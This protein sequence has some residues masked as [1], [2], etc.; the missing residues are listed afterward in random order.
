[1][2]LEAACTTK[3]A[4]RPEPEYNALYCG[5]KVVQIKRSFLEW[6]V[7]Y[8]DATPTRRSETEHD[9]ESANR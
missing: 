5:S 2:V 1:M 4:Q 9:E 6:V 7:S 3:H 8:L